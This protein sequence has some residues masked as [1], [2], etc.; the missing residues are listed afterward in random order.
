MDRLRLTG[1]KLQ[2]DKKFNY[3]DYRRGCSL[4]FGQGNWQWFTLHP[5]YIV[6]YEKHSLKEPKNDYNYHMITTKRIRSAHTRIGN[7]QDQLEMG[8]ERKRV[9]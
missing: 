6:S 5:V 1:P 8:E 4:L 2:S 3:E 9:G 7:N